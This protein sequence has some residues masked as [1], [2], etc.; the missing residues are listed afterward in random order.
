MT[1]IFFQD[2]PMKR[3]FDKY[4]ELLLL[5]ATYKLT[6]THMPLY[7]MLC[8][9]PNGESEI[10][11]V[12]LTASEDLQSL[13]N[14]LQLFKG[15]NPAWQQVRT[16]MTDKDM[17]EREAIR[18]E[19]PQASLLL[20]LFHVLRAMSREVTTAKM[21]LSEAQRT[22]ALS[23][24]QQIAYASSS[25]EYDRQYECLKASMLASVVRYFDA[26]WHPCRR[27]RVLCWQ[28]ENV[29]FGERTNNRLESVNRRLKAVVRSGSSLPQF[30]KDL[31]AAIG[32]MR[33]EREQAL[34]TATD[35]L[36]S[37]LC[38]RFRAGTVQQCP[39]TLCYQLGTAAASVCRGKPAT[40]SAPMHRQLACLV[41]I[42]SHTARIEVATYS[43]WKASG[44]AGSKQTPRQVDVVCARLLGRPPVEHVWHSRRSA[45]LRCR[46]LTP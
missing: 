3:F 5:D 40:A 4:P 28:R 12:F 41:V 21:A 33:H 9:G 14:Q 15:R 29:T 7:V 30:F 2:G 44:H 39:H 38:C 17:A 20:C 45:L 22:T 23:C 6:N 10:V 19:L 34:L 25:E 18:Q 1:G 24:L 16:V 8:V 27:E 35:S 43:R 13:T 31:M 32:C 36:R 46:T 37:A 42:C 11:A 26:N